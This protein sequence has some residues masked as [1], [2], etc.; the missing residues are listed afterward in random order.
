MH[1]GCIKYYSDIVKIDE[2]HIKCCEFSTLNSNQKVSDRIIDLNSSTETIINVGEQENLKSKVVKDLSRQ[3]EI[4]V[5]ENKLLRRLI[6]EMEDKNKL[7]TF[8]IEVLERDGN[9]GVGRTSNKSAKRYDGAD[10]KYVGSDWVQTKSMICPGVVSSERIKNRS[11]AQVDKGKSNVSVYSNRNQK[12]PAKLITNDASEPGDKQNFKVAEQDVEYAIHENELKATI[13]NEFPNIADSPI[14]IL[15]PA[16]EQNNWMKVSRKR[17]MR[18]PRRT[19]VVGNCSAD[20]SVVGL[21]KTTT[22]HVS[23]LNPDTSVDDLLAFLRRKFDSVKCDILTSRHPNLYSSFKV[24]VAKA[25]QDEIFLASN[26]PQNA[27][28]R[29]FFFQRR[30]I[31]E[32]S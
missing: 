13:N 17:Q 23:N 15:N 21:E 31:V 19:M 5:N 4:L 10:D 30:G 26:W 1:P 8:K 7:L 25:N 28:V 2:T 9:A 24:T 3:N 29:H 32:P 22:L 20:T 27:H 6:S 14:E 12:S 16:M 11:L 18:K